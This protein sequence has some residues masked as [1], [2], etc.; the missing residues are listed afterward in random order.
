MS[1][2]DK[3]M[4]LIKAEIQLALKGLVAKGFAKEEM[5]NGEPHYSLT[6]AGKAFVESGMLFGVSPDPSVN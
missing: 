5:I 4:D 1:T 6:E 2:K 3:D